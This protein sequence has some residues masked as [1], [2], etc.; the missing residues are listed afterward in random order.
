[1]DWTVYWF[2]FPACVLIAAVAMFSGISGAAL[3]TPVFLIGF[4]LFD[5]PRLSTVEAIGTSLLLE[6]SGFG[7]GVY[8][9]LTLRLVD[10]ATAGALVA[11]TLPVGVLG[12]IAAR[13]V[14]SQAL[15]IGYG[16]AMVALAWLLSRKEPGLA[17]DRNHAAPALVVESDRAH[18]PCPEGERRRIEAAG[19][20]LYEYCAHGLGLQRLVS[21]AGAFVAGLIST[22]VGE[23]TLPGLVRRSHLPV[24]VAAATSTMVVAATVTGAAATHLVELAREGGLSAIPW[25]LVV[26]AVPGAAIGAFIGTHLQGRVS[27]DAAR[28]FFSG[29]FLAIGLTFLVA[30]TAFKGRF[31]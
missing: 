3:L 31:T 23:A 30:F 20:T 22:G 28:R 13:H 6:T 15:R 17:A 24:A 9:Y 29:L 2:M 19:G 4:P 14:P 18:A 7:A 5:V 26:W 16:A 21:G 25:N 8:R 11:I 12:A 1:M 10:L 27:E